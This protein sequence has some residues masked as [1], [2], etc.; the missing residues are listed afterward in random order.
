M[1]GGLLLPSIIPIGQGNFLS[2]LEPEQRNQTIN[3]TN[4]K[5]RISGKPK[6]KKR[7]KEYN[8]S[9]TSTGFEN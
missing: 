6:N 3:S 2:Y 4:L 7:I 5:K 1:Y 8:S 9:R